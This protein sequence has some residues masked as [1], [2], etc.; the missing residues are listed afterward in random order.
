MYGFGWA[1]MCP[2]CATPTLAAHQDGKGN[3]YCQTHYNITVLGYTECMG[4]LGTG[5]E[6]CNS[7]PTPGSPKCRICK[8][9]GLLDP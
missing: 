9:A 3:Y 2:K 5:K 8:G 6:H 1:P 7:K 4:C